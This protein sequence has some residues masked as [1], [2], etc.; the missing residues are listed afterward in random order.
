VPNRALIVELNPFYYFVEIVRQPLLG[1]VPPSSIWL[2]VIGMSFVSAALL[3]IFLTKYR[4]RI[5]YWL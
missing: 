4:S 2:P 5:P 1:Q 3:M